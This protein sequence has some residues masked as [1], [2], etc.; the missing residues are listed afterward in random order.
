MASSSLLGGIEAG[1]TKFICMVGRRPEDVVD[2]IRIETAEPL[3]T[4]A[5]VTAFFRPYC[6]NGQVHRIGV[7]SFGPLDLDR[8]SPTY[9]YITSTPK[10]GWRNANLLGAIQSALPV[11]V[12][13]DTDVDAA[14]LGE[15]RWGAGRGT[16]SLLYVTVGTG[17]GGGFIQDGLPLHGAHHPE[18]GH[19][20]ISHD[21]AQDPF[22]GICPFHGDCFEGLAS[23]PAIQKRFGARPETLQDDEPFWE[24]EA[25]YIASA[26]AA[27]VLVLSPGR[28]VLGGGVMRRASMFPKIRK[29]VIDL[30]GGYLQAP[31]P[32]D[33]M[34]AYILPPALGERSGVFG[35]LALAE[36]AE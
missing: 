2:E 5:K 35:A 1:G 29:L 32:R 36:R 8:Q 4:L 26:L 17:I 22:L 19:I 20:M 31:S 23:G 12:A 3:A 28:I 9:G 16:G 7:G 27:Y 11:Q 14:A 10:P 24:V 33:D 21:L 25:Q 6:A 15:Y 13:I 18:M 30:L 34:G